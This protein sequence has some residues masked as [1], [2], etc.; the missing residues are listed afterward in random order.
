MEK[1]QFNEIISS[2]TTMSNRTFISVSS[3]I[4]PRKSIN[5][6]NKIIENTDAK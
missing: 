1:I 6:K 5:R 2:Q 4:P 3:Q